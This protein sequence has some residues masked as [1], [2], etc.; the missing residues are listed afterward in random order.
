MI[1]NDDLKIIESYIGQIDKLLPYPRERKAKALKNLQLD[2]EE[3]M[4]ES[5]KKNPSLVFG[6]PREVA[7]D[8]SLS[9]D[10]GTRKAGFLIR[11]I[12]FMVDSVISTILAIGLGFFLPALAYSFFDP[13]F[14][15]RTKD[16]LTAGTAFFLILSLSLCIWCGY[17][18]IL[19]GL[20]SA[21]I[22]KR[23]LGLRVIDT[24]GIKITWTQAFVRNISKLFPPFF[25]LDIIGGLLQKTDNQRTLD[26]IAQTYVIK[27]EKEISGNEH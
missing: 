3:E 13:T 21:T 6:L 14:F 23:L 22:G 7:K 15:N 16:T 27:L 4:N 1:Q 12:P 26:Q 19:E 9:Q 17:P 24:S 8:I 11:S 2:V 18:I 25:L 5:G 20:F 10:W